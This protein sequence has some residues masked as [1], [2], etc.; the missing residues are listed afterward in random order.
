MDLLFA[1]IEGLGVVLDILD[2]LFIFG[3]VIS[4]IKGKE[5]RI[6]RKSAKRSGGKPPKR[7]A[8]NRTFILFSAFIIILTGLIIIRIL[9]K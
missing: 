6:E 3:D 1:I 2:L 7:N 4:W 8:W 9:R 5:N